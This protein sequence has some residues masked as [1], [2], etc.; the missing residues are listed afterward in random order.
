MNNIIYKVEFIRY[1]EDIISV[2]SGTT[3]YFSDQA[4]ADIEI[5]L[6]QSRSSRNEARTTI[7]EVE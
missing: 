1:D 2:I 3:R 7:V 4:K 5:S 6:W